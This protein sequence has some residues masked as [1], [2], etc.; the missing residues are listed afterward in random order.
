MLRN[1][2]RI[3]NQSPLTC[4]SSSFGAAAITL[5][6]PVL[7]Y[8]FTFACN[9][10]AGCPVPSLLNPRTLSWEKLMSEIGW[11][12]GGIR[13]LVSWQV[14]G[15]VLAYYMLSL[16]LWR[17]LPAEEVQGT[18]LVQH[19]RPL[20]YR[21]NGKRAHRNHIVELIEANF[22][23]QAFS[24]T[25]VHFAI[26]AIG[27][28]LQGADFFVWTYMADN[29]IQILSANVI[30]AYSL[31]TFLYVRSFSVNTKY[32]NSDLRELAAGGNTG[33]LIYDFYIGRELN[34]RV[35]LPIFGEIDIK[36][37]CEAR[38]GLTGWILFDLAFVA[39]QYRT[40]GYLSDSIVFTTFVQ[41][42][43]VLDAQYLESGMLTMMDITTD[44]M[45][46]MLSFGDLVWVPFLY[47]TQCRYLSVYPVHLGWTGVAAVSAV[48]VLGLYIFRAANSQ[49]N[50][51]RTR[52]DDPSVANLSYIQT[53]R[54]TRL[55]TAGW[56]GMSRHINYFGDWLQA[57]PFS[58][59]TGLAGYTII[60]AGSVAA[61]SQA[62]KMLDGREVVQGEA[63]GWGI[64]FT[65]FYVLYFAVLL[66]HRERRDDAMCL[67]KYG[68]DWKTY[69]KMVRWRILPFVY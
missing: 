30:I 6:L 46:F 26:G 19:G 68:E 66:M 53:K 42:Y 67:K 64:L 65:Y 36:T 69:K 28:Y 22:L 60:P 45:G 31:A 39:K 17:F 49:K 1:I 23:L 13:D 63:R 41:A 59:P 14:T 20:K 44:G 7:L 48:F 15:V 51:F 47:S 54:G 29:Y 5:G 58:M 9:D 11:P 43:Y 55:L 21:L 10:A 32:P 12:K 61:T 24:A 62:I 3:Q 50:V 40:Y 4:S 33:N 52:P 38:P 34:P 35:T 27:T 2:S 8:F 56:W 25:I 37:W 18:K 16:V 57:S